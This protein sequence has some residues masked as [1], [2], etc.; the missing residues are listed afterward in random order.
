MAEAALAMSLDDLIKKSKDSKKPSSKSKGGAGAKSSAVKGR[1]SGLGVKAVGVKKGGAARGGIKV[2][3]GRGG[4]SRPPRKDPDST[5][6]HDMYSEGPRRNGRGRVGGGFPAGGRASDFTLW[7]PLAL[8]PALGSNP[9]GSVVV[10]RASHGIGSP[11]VGC[12]RS[13]KRPS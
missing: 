1:G 12:G 6:V 9:V 11:V 4:G 13:R 2:G 3:G 10:L 8:R 7:V 5:W